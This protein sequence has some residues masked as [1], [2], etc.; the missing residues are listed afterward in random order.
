MSVYLSVHSAVS[1]FAHPSTCSSSCP[2][3]SPAPCFLFVSCLFP[4]CLLFISCSFPTCC[5]FAVYFMFVSCLFPVC[6]LVISCLFP[7]CLLF[8]SCSFFP[9]HFL[10]FPV[11]FLFVS[12]LFPVYILFLL[13][14]LFPVYFLFQ[15]TCL[16][17]V[18]NPLFLFAGFSSVFCL[19]AR[20]TKNDPWNDLQQDALSEEGANCYEIKLMCRVQQNKIGFMQNR[21]CSSW[22]VHSNILLSLTVL[23]AYVGRHWLRRFVWSKSE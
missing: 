23:T 3:P 13:S 10:L 22:W 1:L 18:L 20:P 19:L 6:F 21:I 14:C 15:L 7:V 17:L 9:V 8:I 16:C 11:R 5:L 2:S 12:R 4:V